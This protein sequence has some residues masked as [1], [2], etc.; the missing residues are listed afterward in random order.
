MTDEQSPITFSTRPI[1]LGE[2]E[3]FLKASNG[4]MTALIDII[5]ARS[6]PKVTRATVEAL[7]PSQV[8]LVANAL[9]ES[10]DTVNYISKLFDNM[11]KH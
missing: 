2:L 11:G 9:R 6:E 8:T 1:S 7:I 10:I 3:L 4:N 5:V